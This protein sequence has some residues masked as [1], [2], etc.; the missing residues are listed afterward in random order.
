MTERFTNALTLV[1]PW[2]WARTA[3]RELW[4][5][6]G[7]SALGGLDA[8]DDVLWGVVYEDYHPEASVRMSIAI[9]DPKCVTRRA[10]RAV[11]G[12][13]FQQLGVKKVFA[14]VDDDNPKS[15]KFCQ[16]LGFRIEAVLTGLQKDGDRYILAMHRTECKW[17]TG[18]R[19][20]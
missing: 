2:V 1:G 9:S 20:G 13:A 17:L 12:Y 6:V 19:H 8:N 3:E 10:I 7:R 18:D 5:T 15:L 14:W 11:F 16:Q 4:H